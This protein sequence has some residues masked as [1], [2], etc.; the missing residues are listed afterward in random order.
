[1][2]GAHRLL[3]CDS[4]HVGGVYQGKSPECASCHR[5]AAD[6]VVM[7]NHKLPGFEQCADCHNEFM[8]RGARR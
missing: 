8:F 5:D 2:R 6:Q 4:C 3:P 1:L 7:P